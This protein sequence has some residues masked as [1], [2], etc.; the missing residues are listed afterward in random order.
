MDTGT[1]I[2]K[3]G[4]WIATGAGIAAGAYATY[5][6]MTWLR[7]GRVAPPTDEE[8]DALLDRIMPD[9]EVVERHHV[10]VDAPAAITFAAARGLD[11]N[12]GIARLIFN[13]RALALGGGIDRRPAVPTPFVDQVQEIGWRVLA[14]FPGSEIV[15][16]AVTRPWEAEPEFRSIPPAEF[17]AFSE[18]EYVKIVFTLRADAVGNDASIFRTETRACTTDAAARRKFRMYWAFVKPGVGLIRRFMLGPVKCDA[19]RRA[20][21]AAELHPL[22]ELRTAV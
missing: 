21:K 22:T 20:K 4:R 15:F 8:D 10:L 2:R 16:G 5:A 13:A 17:A 6:A 18:P 19:E 9:Y 12:S 3:T 7:Y 1:S 11:F 14:E